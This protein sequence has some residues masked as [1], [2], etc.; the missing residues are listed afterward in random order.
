[1]NI[2]KHYING[3]C[4]NIDCKYEHVDNICKF[5]YFGECNRLNCKFLH[6]YKYLYIKK[7]TETF[8][9]NYEKCSMKIL[10][11]KPI[12]NNNEISINNN[13]FDTNINYYNNLL[14]EI[15]NDVYLPWHGESHLIANDKSDIDWKSKSQTFNLVINKLSEYFNLIPSSTRLN[16]YDNNDWK[17]YHHDAAAF[18]EEKAK[19]QNI[20]V[21]VSFGAERE[22]SFES[23]ENN[24]SSRKTI[25]FLLENCT[26]YAFG[27][28][29]NQKF[30]H[31]IPPIINNNYNNDNKGRISIIIWGYTNNLNYNF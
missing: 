3:K 1:M 31:G 21:G 4:T 30:R 24:K 11:N 12:Y 18:D 19:N 2:C 5:Y 7:N 9:P 6:K 28:E 29:I 20:T 13:I 15:N 14:K 27:N 25:N 16:F 8:E 17:P 23:A 10:I 22:I 26:V